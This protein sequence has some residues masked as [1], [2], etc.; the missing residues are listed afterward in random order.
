MN[1]WDYDERG[2]DE[3]SSK[4]M[5]MTGNN[6]LTIIAR[7]KEITTRAKIHEEIEKQERMRRQM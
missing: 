4:N 1:P 2:Q 7:E 3:M 5:Y 6:M